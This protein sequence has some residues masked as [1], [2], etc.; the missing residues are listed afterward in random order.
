MRLCASPV[1]SLDSPAAAAGLREGC[2]GGDLDSLCRLLLVDDGD[3]ERLFS[4]KYASRTLVEA[5]PAGLD[6]ARSV[7]SRRRAVLPRGRR[8]P[9]VVCM[10]SSY[11]MAGGR[12]AVA[13]AVALAAC[14]V[15]A[16]QRRW[17]SQEAESAAARVGQ[18]CGGGC[19][20]P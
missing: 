1:P 3:D 11:S 4:A 20:A 6:E 5:A 7:F 15:A 19:V 13:K 18:G 2:G 14:R 16:A 17:L 10:D 8:G 9:L 12:E